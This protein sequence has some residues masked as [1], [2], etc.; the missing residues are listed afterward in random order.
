MRTII[1][2]PLNSLVQALAAL[3]FA[4]AVVGLL[5]GEA[6]FENASPQVAEALHF[7]HSSEGA[8]AALLPPLKTSFA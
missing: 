5:H 2:G 3:P 1:M 6:R 4:L 7:G 8:H